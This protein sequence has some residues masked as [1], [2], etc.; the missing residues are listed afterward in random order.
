MRFNSHL[1]IHAQ[2]RPS[3]G[4]FNKSISKL[5]TKGIDPTP[6]TIHTGRMYA[7]F[8]WARNLLITRSEMRDSEIAVRCHLWTWFI[9]QHS[10]RFT[11]NHCKCQPFQHLIISNAYVIAVVCGTFPN[12]WL[13]FRLDALALSVIATATWL[14]GWLGG[15]MGGCLSQPVLY[16]H[17]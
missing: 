2:R 13:V 10:N 1:Y 6:G 17:D 14:A 12:R 7:T 3:T 4:V 5:E 11:I 8:F 16:Q 9:H 15:W